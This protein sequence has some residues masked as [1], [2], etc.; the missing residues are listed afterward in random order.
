M[1]VIKDAVIVAAG[2][3]GR[4]LPTS[5]YLAKESLPL[6]DI[7]AIIHLIR[8]VLDA[9]IS[10]IHIITSPTKDFT[11]FIENKGDLHSL[12]PEISESLFLTDESVE[13]LLHTQTEPLGLGHAILQSLDSING[14][15]LVLLGD[16]I[17]TDNFSSINSF[18]PS[19]ASRK[20]ISSYMATGLPCAGI[21]SIARNEVSSYG[22]IELD[23]DKIINI[24]EKPDLE[25]A[26]SNKVLC[27]RYIFTADAK[28]LLSETFPVRVYGEFQTIELQKHWMKDCGLL[29][30][31]LSEYQWYDSGNP[32]AWLKAQIDYGLR[33]PDYSE[34]LRQW[35]NERLD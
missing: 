27:G 5:A 13:F 3:G 15:C 6:V 14:P 33:N 2:L 29:A 32:Y 10:R 35:L 30:I 18:Q 11:P 20:L 16:N 12:K 21:Y 26:P 24:V 8:E 23:G 1:T 31:D 4:M 17:I 34:K 25:N 7:P 22:V 9:G 19:T 28:K